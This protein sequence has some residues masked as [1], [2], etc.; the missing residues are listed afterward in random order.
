MPHK[1]LLHGLGIVLP[2]RTAA[3]GRPA[4]YKTAMFQ[5]KL[6]RALH[7]NRAAAFRS[8]AVFKFRMLYQHLR[9]AQHIQSS[10]GCLGPAAP[11][12][13][14]LQPHRCLQ[15]RM[16]RAAVSASSIQNAAGKQMQQTAFLIN[17]PRFASGFKGDSFQ[18]NTQALTQHQHTGF[19]NSAGFQGCPFHGKAAA[20]NGQAGYAIGLA[21]KMPA[22]SF[23]DPRG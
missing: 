12:L 13:T 5:S 22:F 14:I 6:H 16:N 17:S 1:S 10:A 4:V 18:L 21:L 11:H 3:L 2:N 20:L 23:S 8:F 15:R 7:R 19:A 9:A